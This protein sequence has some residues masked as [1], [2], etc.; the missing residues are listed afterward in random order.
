MIIVVHKSGRITNNPNLTEKIVNEM[1]T[2]LPET[3]F[4]FT[5]ENT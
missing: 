3:I 5:T 4:L 2:I 1:A